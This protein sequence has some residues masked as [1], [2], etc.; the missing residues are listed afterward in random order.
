MQASIGYDARRRTLLVRDPGARN[1][2]EFLAEPMLERYRAT[3]PRGMALVPREK[4]ALL[5]GIDLPDAGLHDQMYA[6]QRALDSHDRDAA[7]AAFDAMHAADPRHRLTLMAQRVLASYDADPTRL[8]AC[9]DALLELY[10]GD[11]IHQLTR[12]SCLRQLARRDERLALL[13]SVCATRLGPRF[14]AAARRGAVGRRAAARRRSCAAV[15]RLRVRPLEAMNYF[16]LGNL[17]WDQRLFAEA[18]PMYRF[19]AC[20]EDKQER[21]AWAYFV[22][23]RHLKRTD[24]GIALLKQRFE[25]FGEKSG[26]PGRTLFSAY[27]DLDRTPEAF[28]VLKTALRLLPDDGDLLLYAADAFSRH[29]DRERAESLLDEARHKARRASWLRSAAEMARWRGDLARRWGRGEKCSN[30]SRWPL[31]HTARSCCC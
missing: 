21:F 4:A 29:G 14:L 30:W 26:W 25:R 6:V 24:E 28:D 17:L 27:A 19:A 16:L 20:L 8:L 11:G 18:L 10:P 23:T 12:L 9:T 2:S 22:A 3:G 31:T 7:Q 1:F 5:D 15:A 13:E